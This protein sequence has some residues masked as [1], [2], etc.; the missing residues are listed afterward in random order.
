[1]DTSQTQPPKPKMFERRKKP[2]TMGAQEAHTVVQSHLSSETELLHK[3]VLD[4]SPTNMEKQP[5]SSFI[6]FTSPPSNTSSIALIDNQNFLNSPSMQ[7]REEPTLQTHI[8]PSRETSFLYLFT[9]DSPNIE[10]ITKSFT[11]TDNVQSTD[12]ISSIDKSL[13]MDIR[14]VLLG[15]M[16]GSDFLSEGHARDLAKGED[17]SERTPTSSGGAKGE[18]EG[19]TLEGEE[20]GEQLREVRF[21]DE[22]LMQTVRKT[23]DSE[24]LTSNFIDEQMQIA[25]LMG[26][27]VGEVQIQ[28]SSMQLILLRKWD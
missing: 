9:I 21:Q 16:E 2:K 7:L 19:T 18:N 24:D 28:L 17:V 22:I 11:S 26:I 12:N 27:K 15:M 20:K 8:S 1:M 13:S 5:Y 3:S 14:E 6:P 23:G 4:A 25:K 10:K